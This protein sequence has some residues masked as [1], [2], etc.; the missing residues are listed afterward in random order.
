MNATLKMKLAAGLFVPAVALAGSAFAQSDKAPTTTGA[1][2]PPATTGAAAGGSMTMA[3]K[4]ALF[5]RL[6]TNNDGMLSAAEAQKDS[7]LAGKWKELDA[8]N[9]GSISK[10]EFLSSPVHDK[11]M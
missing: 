2:T 11:K 8:A 3:D 10:A 5:A 9:K 1:T 7:K 6:D 4:E